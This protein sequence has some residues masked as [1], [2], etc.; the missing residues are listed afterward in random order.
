M[1]ET[2]PLSVS[3]CCTYVCGVCMYVPVEG[4]LKGVGGATK[5][6]GREG[7]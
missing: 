2:T 4:A 7:G 1:R 3:E 5:A 6:V